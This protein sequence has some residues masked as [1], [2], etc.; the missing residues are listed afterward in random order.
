MV[1][2]VACMYAPA[3]S[4]ASG[5]PPSSA[6]N[7]RADTRS[8][9]PVRFTRK[10]AATSVSKTGTSRI[11]PGGQC[12][13]WV[14]T[15]TRPFPAGGTNRS[16]EARS[17]T[18]SNTSSHPVSCRASTACTD[19]TGSRASARSRAPSCAAS[20]AKSA[21]SSA[22]SSAGN[23]QHTPTSARCR[24]AYS[25]ATLV[26][27]APP[28]PDNAASRG[29]G[30]PGPTASRSSRSASSSSRPTRNTGRGASRTGIPGASVRRR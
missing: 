11:W 20:T 15:S 12:W 24:C 17:V 18:L 1:V 13:D 8:V 19:A 7:S 21:D 10:P 22:G 26:L 2:A 9:S 4:S 27:P 16:T 25:T 14:V 28:S 6:A 5:S 23:C 29:P 30:R 3:C